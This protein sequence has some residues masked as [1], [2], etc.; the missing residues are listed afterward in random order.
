MSSCLPHS[1]CHITVCILM[2][3]CAYIFFTTI[4]FD[5]PTSRSR[6][7][8]IPRRLK[9]RVSPYVSRTDSLLL[10]LCISISDFVSDVWV[11]PQS[12][13]IWFFI[14]FRDL[15]KLSFCQTLWCIKC[16]LLKSL[17]LLSCT[18]YV[19]LLVWDLSGSH[20]PC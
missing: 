9:R 15:C 3:T 17:F 20:T 4:G 2:Q 14:W 5:A 8:L 11:T 1:Y 10:L 7:Y 18:M 16:Y 13:C 6:D 12:L 19:K